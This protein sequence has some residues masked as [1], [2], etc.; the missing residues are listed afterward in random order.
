MDKI[1]SRVKFIAT[2]LYCNHI[3]S[4]FFDENKKEFRVLIVDMKKKPKKGISF[5]GPKSKSFKTTDELKEYFD[6]FNREIVIKKKNE[7]N[8]RNN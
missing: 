1:I 7:F 8:Q 5:Y 6:L 4:W 3:A 2:N